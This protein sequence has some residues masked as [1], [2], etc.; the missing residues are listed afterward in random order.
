MNYLHCPAY[1]IAKYSISMLEVAS[2]G[3]PVYHVK[4]CV[5]DDCMCKILGGKI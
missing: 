5:L 2:S 4:P 3:R 1:Y